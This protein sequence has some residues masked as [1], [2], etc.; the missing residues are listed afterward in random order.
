[1]QPQRLLQ[2]PSMIRYG[3]KDAVCNCPSF[4]SLEPSTVRIPPKCRHIANPTF[5]Q[6]VDTDTE[7]MLFNHETICSGS[8][9]RSFLHHNMSTE[10]HLVSMS[11]D[12]NLTAIDYSFLVL[13]SVYMNY[14]LLVIVSIK[15]LY[16][17]VVYHGLHSFTRSFLI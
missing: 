14:S 4:C 16:A 10:Q 15:L 17:A 3:Q 1:M 12:S 9:F 7:L 5:A 8:V 13:V 2:R 6:R 11:Y